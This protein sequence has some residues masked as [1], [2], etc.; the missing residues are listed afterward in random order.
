MFQSRGG[1]HH[2]R[3]FAAPAAPTS[4]SLSFPPPPLFPSFPR[5]GSS[6]PL[7]QSSDVPIR[8]TG[9]PV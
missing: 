1:R 4:L 2:L 7:L 5:S 6:S 8:A 9:Q 3:A